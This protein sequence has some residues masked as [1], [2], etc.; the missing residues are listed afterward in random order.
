MQDE[1]VKVVNEA[2]VTANTNGQNNY[3]P[4]AVPAENL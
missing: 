4:G 1:F 2:V 3:R